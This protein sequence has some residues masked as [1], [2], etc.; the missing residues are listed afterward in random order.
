MLIP[1]AKWPFSLFL[2]AMVFL[3][4]PVRQGHSVAP[5][6]ATVELYES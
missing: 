3:I 4:F 1:K 6:G 5:S 2:A